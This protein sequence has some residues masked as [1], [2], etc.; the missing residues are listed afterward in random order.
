MSLKRL[1]HSQQA[2]SLPF[3]WIILIGILILV[4]FFGWG[5]L[6]IAIALVIVITIGV[7]LYDLLSVD[8]VHDKKSFWFH[9]EKSLRDLGNVIEAGL[10]TDP[11]EHDAENVWEWIEAKSK[12]GRYRYNVTRRHK[13]FSYPVR[14]T[15]YS[16]SG[17]LDTEELNQ[18]GL[19]L[20]EALKT[21]VMLGLV[22]Y[23]DGNEYK[24]TEEKAF[25][26]ST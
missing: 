10:N 12:D 26:F 24:F 20:A 23:I 8:K 3:T 4:Y 13:D 18:L 21:D 17:Y 15:T 6:L 11:F 14:I 7:F 16:R 5:V 25:R 22:E 1:H 19:R 2:F 9:S